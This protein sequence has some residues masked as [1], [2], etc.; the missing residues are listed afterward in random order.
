MPRF[1]VNSRSKRDSSNGREDHHD[2]MLLLPGSNSIKTHKTVPP[3]VPC[4]S[5]GKK[6]RWYVQV[7]VTATKKEI[8]F[9]TSKRLLDTN[10]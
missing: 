7:V 3:I 9:Y 8:Q 5:Q 4:G 2:I 1:V 6:S 10:F